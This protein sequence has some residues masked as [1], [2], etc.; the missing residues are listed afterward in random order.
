MRLARPKGA[1]F[2]LVN[3]KREEV[4][5][6]RVYSRA[7]AAAIF[8]V[9]S[10]CAYAQTSG[11]NGDDGA[12]VSAAPTKKEIRAQN[13][14]LEKAVRRAL[15]RTKGLDASGV[16]VIARGGRVTLAGSVPDAS[17]IDLAGKSATSTT[18]VKSVDNRVTVREVGS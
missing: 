15:T 3:S 11:A 2:W 6:L 7:V 16:V 8:T 9:S 10:V 12:T 14:A 17:Q 13:H 4:M 18:G 1:R 5:Q